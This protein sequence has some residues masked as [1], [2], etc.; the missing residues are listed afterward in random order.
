MNQ[1]LSVI[2]ITLTTA[3][4]KRVELT[5]SEA[6]ELHDHLAEMFCQKIV[7]TPIVI[8][9]DRWPVPW[10]PYTPIWTSDRTGDFTPNPYIIEC[11]YPI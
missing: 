1:K 9:R 2:S 3:S 5:L 6:R 10:Q 7:N 4:G 11:S 8:E